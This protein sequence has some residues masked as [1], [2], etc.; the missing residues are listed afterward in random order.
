MSINHL[1]IILAEKLWDFTIGYFLKTLKEFFNP[2]LKLLGKDSLIGEP[3]RIFYGKLQLEFRIGNEPQPT[4]DVRYDS[5]NFATAIFSGVIPPYGDI[6]NPPSGIPLPHETMPIQ[7]R[8][9]ASYRTDS[10]NSIVG[11]QRLVGENEALVIGF[12]FALALKAGLKK[13]ISLSSAGIP[14]PDGSNFSYLTIG[15]PGS[16]AVSAQLLSRDDLTVNFSQGN[17]SI[18]T[19]RRSYTIEG[20]ND[21]AILAKKK[22]MIANDPDRN[23]KIFITAGLGEVGT[24]GAGR[25]LYTHAKELVKTYGSNDFELVLKVNADDFSK[26]KVVYEQGEKTLYWK[27][28]KLIKKWFKRFKLEH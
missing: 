5:D 9:L 21:F 17:E 24:Q 7:L 28:S 19:P 6:N 14:L 1:L 2:Y 15:G 22:N 3:M 23:Y 10:G 13:P 11:P 27:L 25:Y 4:R 18:T 12:T 16:N 8:V 20:R 26:T